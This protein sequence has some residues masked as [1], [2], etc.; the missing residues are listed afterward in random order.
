MYNIHFLAIKETYKLISIMEYLYGNIIANN[1]Y[2]S[3][4]P[5]EYQGFPIEPLSRQFEDTV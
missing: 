3:A 1:L 5:Q 4:E 2:A